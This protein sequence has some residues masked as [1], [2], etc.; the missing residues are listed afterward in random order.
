[1]VN[2]Y[3]PHVLVLPEDDANRQI[4]NG[5]VLD[6]DPSVLPVFKCSKKPAAG[7]RC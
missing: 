1:M 7:A 2:R 4:A 3:L 5:F 6:L